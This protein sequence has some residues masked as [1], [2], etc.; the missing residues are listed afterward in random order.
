MLITGGR[1]ARVVWQPA[2]PQTVSSPEPI[3]SPD[4]ASEGWQTYRNEELGFEVR[5]PKNWIA[6][7]SGNRIEPSKIS[8]TLS[9]GVMAPSVSNV[10]I[11]P[12]AYPRQCP[13]SEPCPGPSSERTIAGKL[14]DVFDSQSERPFSSTSRVIVFRDPKTEYAEF[15]IEMYAGAT[16]K[17]AEVLKIHEAILQTFRFIK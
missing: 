16:G 2:T 3:P 9:E 1:P 15:Q 6:E 11:Q 17:V 8:I 7:V 12:H 10:I 13:A 5:Y 14:A 4:P